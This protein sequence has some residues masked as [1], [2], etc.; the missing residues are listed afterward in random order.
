MARSAQGEPVRRE[1][2]RAQPWSQ[3]THFEREI[4]RALALVR[5]I[6]Q[7]GERRRI[8]LR[9]RRLRDAE[10]S[11]RLR[12]DHPGTDCR[13]EALGQERAERL[14]FPCLNVPR[15]P[16]VQKA[17]AGDMLG[18]LSDRDGTA[19]FVAGTDPD[20]EFRL[21]VQPLGRTEAR[22]G[23]AR[24]LTLAVWTADR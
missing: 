2:L 13:A 17:E 18:R 14:V 12:R 6:Q 23:L 1:I 8:V 4:E 7:V 15:R 9:T 24:R 16:V 19:Q 11:E 10:R 22:L 3:Q 20:S 5:L 21:V